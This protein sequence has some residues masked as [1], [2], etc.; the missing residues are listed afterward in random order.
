MC[1]VAQVYA[2]VRR[3]RGEVLVAICDEEFLGRCFEDKERELVFE[4]RESFYKGEK[5]GV[6]EAV[7]LLKSAT[8]AN[9]TGSR[10]VDAAVEAGYVDKPS[11]AVICGI[12]HAQIVKI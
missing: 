7:K 10:I 11:V 12:S 5:M 3:V 2:K 8:V 1:L 6:N 9:L 4:V